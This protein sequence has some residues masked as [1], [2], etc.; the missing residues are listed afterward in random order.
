[1]FYRARIA[2][3]AQIP[4]A[5]LDSMM[6]DDLGKY[7]IIAFVLFFGVMAWRAWQV[8]QASPQWPSVQGE[9]V[10]ARAFTHTENGP[11][12]GAS[13]HEWYTEV[14]YRYTVSGTT[15]T[16]D[17]LRAFGRHH[18]DQQQAE[19]EI[20]PFPVGKPVTV[21]YDPAKPSASVL[22]PG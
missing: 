3:F 18:F 19:A 9:M 6:F 5:K 12:R 21:Y 14:R 11:D 17:R 8:K 16:G 7:L 15:Y 1:M 13:S 22:I 2:I 10:S 20:A 4:R